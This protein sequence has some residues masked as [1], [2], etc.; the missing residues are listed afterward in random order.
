MESFLTKHADLITASLSCFDRLIFKGYLPLGYASAMEGWLSQRGILLKDFGRFVKRQADRLQQH[1]RA[2]AQQADRP[3]IHLNGRQNKEKLIDKILKDQPV[4]EG[5]IAVVSAVEAGSSFR[6]ASG[7][8]RPRLE[9][10]PRKCLCYYFYY[11]DPVF[12]RLHVR[13]QTWFPLTIQVYLNGHDWLARAMAEEG[14]DFRQQDNCFL[15][16]GHPARAQ[17]LADQL[18]RLNWPAVLSEL[19]ARVN[20][21]LSD[22]LQGLEYYWVVDQAELSTD[23]LFKN[24]ASLQALY[25]E[26][27]RQATLCF[28]AEDVMHFLGRK[29]TPQFQGEMKTSA[30]RREPGSRIKHWMKQNWI[31]MYNKAGLVLRIETVINHPYEFRVRRKGQRQGQEVMGWFPLTKGVK[32]LWRYR[33]VMRSANARYLEALA[34]IENPTAAHKQLERV[35]EPVRYK[36]R[37][38]RGLNPLRQDDRALLKAVMRGEHCI[39]GLRNRDLAQALSL[40]RPKDSQ[41]AR[42][43]SARLTRKLHLLHAHGLIAKIPR[44]RRWR[45]TTKG[46]AVMGAAIHYRERALPEEIMRLAA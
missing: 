15:A 12:G 29:L 33:D 9:R 7:E 6:L 28:G 11:Q 43:Q 32:H 10:A 3:L 36:S 41:T 39:H 42:R 14:L 17:Q 4:A 27:L 45:V 19:A 18:P 1:A 21:L 46:A 44:S 24:A 31:K 22:L 2:V 8:G 16:L 5:L 40:P 20:P 38:Q 34:G 25:G 26:L 37:S 13:L 30:Q 23:V 35:C